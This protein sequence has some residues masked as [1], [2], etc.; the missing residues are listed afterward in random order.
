MPIAVS[1]YI[2][3]LPSLATDWRFPQT[4][5]LSLINLLD[6]LVELRETL[7]YVCQLM[8]ECDEQP[9]GGLHRVKSGTILSTGAFGS[10]GAGVR[11]PPD[12]GVFT[13][14]E[15]FQTLHTLD[16]ILEAF[17]CRYD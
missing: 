5:F 13:S 9:N 4:P 1:H 15:A 16:I 17:S 11:H 8:K 7:T 2:Q 10:H 6:Q 12:T 3:L 14:L